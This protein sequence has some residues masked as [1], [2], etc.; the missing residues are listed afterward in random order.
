MQEFRCRVDHKL[1]LKAC[2]VDADVEIKCRSCGTMNLFKKHEHVD[3]TMLC[4]KE[5]CPNR[6]QQPA[7]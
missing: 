2:L 5:G 6:V 4:Y 1:L 3:P 7:T